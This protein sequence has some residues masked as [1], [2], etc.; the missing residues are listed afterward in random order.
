[1]STTA[2]IYSLA[3]E[4]AARLESAAWT[5]FS[6]AR[7]RAEFCRAWLTI[8]CAQVERVRGAVVLLGP[9][10]DDTYT[11]AAV[12]PD[13]SRDLRHLGVA[14]ER[15]LGERRGIVS[16]ADGISPPMR[17]Q[18]AH[19]AYPIEVSGVLHGAVVLEI[20]ATPEAVLQRALRHVH[21]ASAWLIDWFRQQALAEQDARIS[22]MAMT[23]ELGATAMQERRLSSAALSVANEMAA[24]LKCDRVSIGFETSGDVD[25]QAISHTAIF[26]ARMSLVRL[27]SEAMEEVLDLDAPMVWPPKQSDE[28]GAVAHAAL[29]RELNDVA[30]CSVPLLEDGH[31]I[32]VLTLERTSG[33]E[34]DE[35]TVEL[36]RAIA[37]F[38]GP[39]LSLK[40]E[41]E[42]GVVRRMREGFWEKAGILF[43]PSHPGVK[44]IALVIVGVAIFFSIASGTY[45]IAARTVVEGAVQRAA[46]SPFDGHI[47]Q[48][49][50]RAGDTVQAGQVLCR[51]EDRDLKLERERLVSE[52]EQSVRKQRQALAIQDRGAMMVASAQIAQADAQI[53]LV[54]DRLACSVVTAPFQGIVVSGDLDQ[55]LGT[56]V[57]Q[58][59]L[60]FQIAPLDAYRVIL[61]VDERDIASVDV[62]QT[63]DLTLSGL[64]DQRMDFS[65]QQITPVAS[66][67]EGRNFFRVEAHL[68]SSAAR[69]RP[70]MEGLGKIEVGDRNLLWIW[71]HSLIDWFRFW[72]WKQLP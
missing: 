13:I 7:D 15:A 14:A 60:L 51:L 16:A 56:P 43:G 46:V 24:R 4:E 38:L 67:H 9:E 23:M 70:G 26:D 30:V 8:L 68:R 62:G 17:D 20:G 29:A 34:F 54:E 37:G 59:K 71:T 32:G 25:V 49:Y 45:R 52:R 42:R 35:Q 39:I 3:S 50:V 12:W 53:S 41:N 22:R 2:S 48:A 6:I 36:C 57:E 19:I 65:V 33:D 61:E 64:S 72:A 18:P 40:R 47:A 69:V 44:L 11:P 58:G 1:M 55:L 27:I 10:A 5:R 28:L 31:P 63:G 21:W 66:Q